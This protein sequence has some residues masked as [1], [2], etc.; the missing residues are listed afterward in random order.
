MGRTKRWARAAAG[1][2]LAQRCLRDIASFACARR[3]F[4]VFFLFAVFGVFSYHRALQKTEVKTTS[5]RLR[6]DREEQIGDIEKKGRSQRE[7]FFA[8]RLKKCRRI[9]LSNA[10]VEGNGSTPG[11]NNKDLVYQYL[12]PW[13]PTMTTT[14][15]T[16]LDNSVLSSGHSPPLQES[17]HA[18]LERSP[19]RA[20]RPQAVVHDEKDATLSNIDAGHCVR[21]ADGEIAC[22]PLFLILGTQKSGTTELMNWLNAHPSLRSVGSRGEAH[23]FDFLRK[24]VD[25]EHPPV[26]FKDYAHVVGRSVEEVW[27]DYIDHPTF[28]MKDDSE[29][30]RVFLFDKTPAYFDR[31]DPADVAKMMPSVRLIVLTRDPAERLNSAFYHCHRHLGRRRGGVR[32]C[33]GVEASQGGFIAGLQNVLCDSSVDAMASAAASSAPP[34]STASPE[35][36]VEIDARYFEQ[37]ASEDLSVD[38]WAR[39]LAMGLGNYSVLANRWLRHFPR[40]QL[41][42][43]RHEHFVRDPFRTMSRVVRFLGV[44]EFDFRSISRRVRSDGKKYWT[45]QGERKSK[46]EMGLFKLPLAPIARRWLSEL[47]A[48]ER[49]ATPP[50]GATKGASGGPARDSPGDAVVPI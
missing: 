17:G 48:S 38:F 22:L 33:G 18:L 41:L 37:V 10:D 47:Y 39:Q 21:R 6:G 46:A 42:L 36:R 3:L 29:I 24:K 23:F 8:P 14:T 28:S 25:V 34:S 12:F 4:V 31:A 5:M 9:F 45:V 2:G 19:L 20:S 11:R 1:R 26:L 50:P 27:K 13:L 35:T 43:L 15:A 30:G 16:V 44:D 32:Q 40:D 7:P 49:F